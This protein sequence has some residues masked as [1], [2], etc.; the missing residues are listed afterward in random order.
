[1]MTNKTRRA[2]WKRGTIAF[3]M[4]FSTTWRPGRLC[5]CGFCEGLRWI[6]CGW[7]CVHFVVWVRGLV[8]KLKWICFI[9][10]FLFVCKNYINSIMLIINLTYWVLQTPVWEVWVLWRLW[11]PWRQKY[12]HVQNCWEWYWNLCVYMN[13]LFPFVQRQSKLMNITK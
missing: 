11:E 2:M 13:K 1:M 5:V 8:W 10:W 4:A 3:K 6:V 9:R 12:L 7:V